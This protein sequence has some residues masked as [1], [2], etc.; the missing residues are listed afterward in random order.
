V[1]KNK[2][3]K[4]YY[5][6]SIEEVNKDMDNCIDGAIYKISVEFLKK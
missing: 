3:N 1:R 6:I 5:M 4:E 2:N